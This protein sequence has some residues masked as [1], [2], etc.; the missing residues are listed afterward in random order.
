MA[1]AR[2]VGH[3]E[4]RPPT[5]FATTT[6]TCGRQSDERSILCQDERLGADKSSV[7]A[8]RGCLPVEAWWLARSLG[9]ANQREGLYHQS[10]RA[11]PPTAPEMVP[12]T[13]LPLCVV[14]LLA[15]S[16]TTTSQ[17]RTHAVRTV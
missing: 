13:V 9:T 14:E 6:A 16:D 2:N 1:V 3:G 8:A 17:A 5:S 12:R 11:A 4:G 7:A 10:S 15:P